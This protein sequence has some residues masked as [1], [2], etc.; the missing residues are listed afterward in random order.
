MT[1]KWT[2]YYAADGSRATENAWPTEEWAAE[3]ARG[4]NEYVQNR[5]SEVFYADRV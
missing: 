1:E 3:M 2:L 5:P 4:H